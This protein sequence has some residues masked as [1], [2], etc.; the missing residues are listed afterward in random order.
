MDAAPAG[1][2]GAGK[3]TGHVAVAETAD[4]AAPDTMV[5][6]EMGCAQVDSDDGVGGGGGCTEE[7]DEEEGENTMG[8][9]IIDCD[10]KPAVD[11]V[12]DATGLMK[13]TGA[14]GTGATIGG[15]ANV[16]GANTGN[17]ALSRVNDVGAVDGGTDKVDEITLGGT[18]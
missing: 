17:T 9:R 13:V 18:T 7:A 3:D 4:A 2:D 11:G 8:T 6:E 5:V 16:T 1:N 10:W 15:G 14:T 12:V